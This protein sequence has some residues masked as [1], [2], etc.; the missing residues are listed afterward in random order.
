[1]EKTKELKKDNIEKLKEE[2]NEIKKQLKAQP[3]HKHEEKKKEEEVKLTCY[4]QIAKQQNGLP[5]INVQGNIIDALGLLQYASL[6]IEK[7]MQK[8][9]E[10]QE[11]GEDK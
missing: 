4:I 9:I 3:D 7:E 6:Y 2:L 10:E 1:M 8:F 5:V 11:K